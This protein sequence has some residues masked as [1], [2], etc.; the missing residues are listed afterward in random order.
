MSDP[1]V[2]IR[3]RLLIGV[4]V[5]GVIVAEAMQQALKQQA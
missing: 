3:R 4:S 5:D 2:Y 1:L